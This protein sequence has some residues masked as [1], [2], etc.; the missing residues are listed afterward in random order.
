MK[1]ATIQDS[2]CTACGDIVAWRSFGD[3]FIT[4]AP[5]IAIIKKAEIQKEGS[6]AIAES[7]AILSFDASFG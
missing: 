6:T 1:T 2:K 3:H 5:T 7:D 4:M